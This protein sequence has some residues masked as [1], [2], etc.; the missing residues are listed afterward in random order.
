MKHKKVWTIFSMVIVIGLFFLQTEAEQF[1]IG[2]MPAYF[3]KTG[4]DYPTSSSQISDVKELG[5]N[6]LW[7]TSKNMLNFA[8]DSGLKAIYYGNNW[9]MKPNNWN[10]GQYAVYNSDLQIP[11]FYTFCPFSH[12]SVVGEEVPDPL[13][14][15]GFAW[16]VGVNEYP[17][18]WAQQ[19]LIVNY[20]QDNWWWDM[21]FDIEYK[22][23][24]RLK[25]NDNT[26][27]TA[28]AHLYVVAME[29]GLEET[30][31]HQV[32]YADDFAYSG[33]YQYFDLDFTLDTSEVGSPEIA[34]KITVASTAKKGYSLP[35]MDYQIY[36]YDNVDLWIDR[37]EIYDYKSEPLLSGVYDSDI[38]SDLASLASYSAPHRLSIRDEPCEDNYPVSIYI[39]SYIDNAGYKG[40]TDALP[41]YAQ[42]R[43]THEAPDYENYLDEYHHYLSPEEYLFN[44]LT[45]QIQWWET[46]R[47]EGLF[48]NLKVLREKSLQNNKDFYSTIL[49]FGWNDAQIQS[50]Q[51]SGRL[52]DVPYS[53]IYDEMERRMNASVFE[54]LAYGT[55]GFHY[56]NIY[57][58]LYRS[59]YGTIRTAA[60]YYAKEINDK[61]Q[62]LADHLLNLTSTSAFA[63]SFNEIPVN[64]FVTYVSEDS[65][66]VG[67][68]EHNTTG[69]IYFMLVN[70]RWYSGGEKTFMIKLNCNPTVNCVEDILATVKPWNGDPNCVSH[71]ILEPDIYGDYTMTV[72]LDAG[73]G[74]LF[75]ISSGLSGTIS[76][77]SYWSGEVLI[78]D[79]IT[80][81][82][83]VSLKIYPGTIVKFNS[84][85]KINVN[86]TLDAHGTN[87]NHIL[88]T[89]ISATPSRGDWDCI[90]FED[91]SDDAN[92]IVKYCEIKYADYG[93]YCNYANPTIENNT[94]SNCNNGIFLNYSS[95]ST[96]KTNLITENGTG[97]YGITSYATIT[98]N[99][100]DDNGGYGVYFSGGA[101]HL[102]DNTFYRNYMGAYIISGSSPNFGP[103]SGDDEGYNI[104]NENSYGIYAQ[105]YSD[106]FLGSTD[107][108][109]NRIG[110]YN[111]IYDSWTRDV[112]A[113]FYT[114]VE[115]EHNY[116]GETPVFLASYASSIDNTPDID[117]FPGGGSSLSKIV[118]QPL[119]L[120]EI[121][122]DYLSAGFNPKKPNPNKLSDLW[123]WGHDLFINSKYEDA[124]EVYQKLVSKFS[125]TEEA[126]KALVKISHLY[127][128]NDKKDLSSYLESIVK[129]SE[130]DNSLKPMAYELL[131]I[132]NFQN[133][134][135][136]DGIQHCQTI[137]DQYPATDEEKMALFNLVL[138]AIN[139]LNDTELASKYLSTMKQKYP[140]D[141]V[142]LMAREAMGEEIN[143]AL[144]KPT[145]D[146]EP[147]ETV[148]PEKYT[149]RNN[150][151]NPF[152]PRT[153]I[154]F[155]LPEESHVTLII[156]D[157][158][159]REVVR[160][161]DGN[162]NEGF[163]HAVWDGK[164][165]S[166]IQVS[167]GVYLY[168]IRTSSGFNATKKMVLVR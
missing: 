93:I 124:I 141:E 143:W 12:T 131:A 88:F 168:S 116:W 71:R 146:S 120:P 23:K 164:D 90:R 100:F 111:S 13:A 142:T 112:T 6:I 162:L 81:N 34:E 62:T 25:V 49:T 19:G 30:L 94:I 48:Y 91:S 84:G 144:F 127:N 76:M 125:D 58:G 165:K 159:G 68:F 77:D 33:S 75:R 72:T 153:T 157:I 14:K 7:T 105:Y 123:L 42:G 20:Q 104:L 136:D 53:V 61:V 99:L 73:E 89:S 57:P 66:V 80:V 50:L 56:W 156:Y 5:I 74:R 152:N 41:E 108:Y 95:P 101:P 40:L 96:V 163:R 82:S 119:K 130:I 60:W 39:K 16:W 32:V 92:C 118:S 113:Y 26:S 70:P 139:S 150:Y 45:Y 140:N 106:P 126:K 31:A 78:A 55:K 17:A 145:I 38:Q 37:V 102:Y 2:G 138:V 151:P 160:L 148:L 54:H 4:Y 64:S 137:L 1:P 167:S 129:N 110:G 98:D 155:D 121:N 8:S 79:N 166:G 83:N 161:V 133:Q 97:I 114:D 63:T 115:A 59:R 3:H 132:D 87:D 10:Y 107:A 149:L 24:F 47:L 117:N 51:N 28:V 21:D 154:A 103:T 46:P 15:N 29:N 67:N 158:S 86:G 27:H 9:N 109:N 147:V 69:Q 44:H 11:Q 65:I 122:E 22:A 52:P 85:K 18:G 135:Y 43:W 35:T 36:W 128:L 134:Q